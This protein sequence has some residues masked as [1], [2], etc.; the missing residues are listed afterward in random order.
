M[1]AAR[2][3]LFVWVRPVRGRKEAAAAWVAAAWNIGV[4]PDLSDIVV[5][6]AGL[7]CYVPVPTRHDSAA[8]PDALPVLTVQ[9]RVYD[10][11]LTSVATDRNIAMADE[12]QSRL[13]TGVAPIVGRLAVC[14]NYPMRIA[15]CFNFD[16]GAA[17]ER[18]VDVFRY[19]VRVLAFDLTDPRPPTAAADP[20]ATAGLAPCAGYSLCDS[21][22]EVLGL[23]GRTA[24]AENTSPLVI[25]GA[26]LGPVR[27]PCVVASMLT[28]QET[29]QVGFSLRYH[30]PADLWPTATLGCFCG[31]VLRDA[32][33][34]LWARAAIATGTGT[35]G[36]L[37]HAS[38]FPGWLAPPSPVET[39]SSPKEAAPMQK[40]GP[41]KE[42]SSKPSKSRSKRRCGWCCP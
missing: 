21:P 29:V 14:N 31:P 13:W 34:H 17:P 19:M 10:L 5:A 7:R 36:R 30:V 2:T 20:L 12:Y 15:S 4:C 18:P 1:P 8:V 42:S 11:S 24:D 28:E 6:Y 22:Q 9:A 3:E 41:N 23:L 35:G 38:L 25:T 27:G 16:C 40:R 39:D 26:A 37:L 32:K 33:G